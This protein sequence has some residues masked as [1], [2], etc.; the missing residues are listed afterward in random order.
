MENKQQPKILIPV[1]VKDELPNDNDNTV[2]CFEKINI[3]GKFY[4]SDNAFVSDE[5]DWYGINEITHW[6]KEV[7]PPKDI[8]KAAEECLMSNCD[9]ITT[10]TY[11]RKKSV[12]KAMIQFALTCGNKVNEDNLEKCV[13]CSKMVPFEYCVHHPE[14]DSICMP[15]HLVLLNDA[16]YKNSVNPDKPSIEQLL[17]D[18]NK[19]S[20]I[21]CRELIASKYGFTSWEAL[22]ME[23]GEDSVNECKD[24]AAELYAEIRV[25]NERKKLKRL[26]SLTQPQ[27]NEAVEFLIWTRNYKESNNKS[28]QQLYELFK[29]HQQQNK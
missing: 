22:Y 25:R 17:P 2:F 8:E 19:K 20:L 18:Q 1:S 12:I 9:S 29:Q 11:N 28:S 3:S 26:Q 27:N 13:S 15:C 5:G 16:E 10:W 14:S 23:L 6:Y 21:D 7:E 4:E 24:E